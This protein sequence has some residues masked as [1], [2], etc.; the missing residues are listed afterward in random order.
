M[1][2]Q[3]KKLETKMAKVDI[4]VLLE[5]LSKCT[6]TKLTYM[7]KY[8]NKMMKFMQTQTDSEIEQYTYAFYYTFGYY[9]SLDDVEQ[10]KIYKKFLKYKCC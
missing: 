8:F 10:R 5:D 4:D 1:S 6:G 9:A 2:Q 7:R 3:I